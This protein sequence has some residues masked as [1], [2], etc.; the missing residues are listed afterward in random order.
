MSDEKDFS[1]YPKNENFEVIDTIGVPHPYCITPQHVGYASDNFGGQLSPQAIR[2]GEKAGKCRCGVKGC[3]L[4]YDEHEQA[5][6]VRCQTK[7]E[8]LTRAYLE[9]IVEMCQEDGYAGFTLLAGEQ[10][11]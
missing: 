4:L 8:D 7:D 10:I 9:S 3:N 1:K 11:Q 5:L 6:V 2:G